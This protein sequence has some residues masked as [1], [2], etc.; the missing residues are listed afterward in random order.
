MTRSQEPDEPW[1][2]D[3]RCYRKAFGCH[4]AGHL[5]PPL[6]VEADL[7]TLL[8]AEQGPA[9]CGVSAALRE[10]LRRR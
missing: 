5:Y 8:T 6:A 4:E 3:W 1:D 7:E 9:R 2:P 10:D